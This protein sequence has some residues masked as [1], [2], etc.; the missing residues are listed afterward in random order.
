MF[1]FE[2]EL[3]TNESL[4]SEWQWFLHHIGVSRVVY[5]KIQERWTLRPNMYHPLLWVLIFLSAP[6]VVMF[7]RGTVFQLWEELIGK[8]PSPLY[9]LWKRQSNGEYRYMSYSDKMS[10]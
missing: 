8:R 2:R 7:T 5:D 3:T 4:F 6:F 10:N 9:K 1:S